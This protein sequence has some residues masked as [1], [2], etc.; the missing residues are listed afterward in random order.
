MSTTLEK[1]AEAV[2]RKHWDSLCTDDEWNAHDERH[3]KAMI[4][5]AMNEARDLLAVLP[6]LGLKLVPVE[7]TREMSRAV[8]EAW[9]GSAAFESAYE[10]MVAAA[11]DVLP[12]APTEERGKDA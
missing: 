11:P 12:E 7:A 4:H 5:D 1:I 2:A 3:R 8:D 9:L 10:I 6:S